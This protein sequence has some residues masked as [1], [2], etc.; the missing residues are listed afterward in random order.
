MIIPGTSIFP[1]DILKDMK[2]DCSRLQGPPVTRWMRDMI[3]YE[4]Y[5][6]DFSEEGTFQG[7]IKN[8]DRITQ[9]GVT[10]IWLM[11]IHPIGVKDRKGSLGCPYAISD[12]MQVNHEYGSESDFRQ[13]VQE[14]HKRG[15]RIFIDMVANHVSPDNIN[16]PINPD[17]FHRDQEG[18]YIRREI[19]WTDV[20]DNDYSN[21]DLR[22]YMKEVIKYWVREFDI[23]GYRCDVAGM[24][25]LDFW[26]EVIDD[27]R[28]IKPEVFM[29]AE[30][31]SR[32]HLC[33]KTFQSD[34]L[35]DLY[36]K[37]VDF[38]KNEFK[39]SEVIEFY[40]KNRRRY[41]V[42]YL[43]LNFIENHDQQP[44]SKLF[45]KKGFRPWAGYIFTIPGIPLIYNGQEAGHTEY[46]SLFDKNPIKWEEEDPET[47]TYYKELIKFRK[48]HISTRDGHVLPLKTNN[49]EMTAAYGLIHFQENLI[50]ILNTS[51]VARDIEVELAGDGIFRPS[52]IIFPRE[53]TT[54]K[55]E[56]N[57][58]RILIDIPADSFVV[59]R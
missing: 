16:V 25:P 11:P 9:L 10:D 47:F 48:S 1:E 46:L 23:D 55:I 49:P 29:L 41:P 31:Y 24:V 26:E 53:F 2:E 27:L 18:N 34:Y 14:T 33:R 28:E 3:L 6:R 8:F 42:N 56:M 38:T 57:E 19:D 12:Y 32:C 45:G 35:G 15:M 7:V 21:P 50:C 54:D 5:V 37:L 39:A 4:V 52:K 58:N 51:P 30:W 43:P 17:W 40:A 13:L 36:L 20:I 44:A 59:L 22:A